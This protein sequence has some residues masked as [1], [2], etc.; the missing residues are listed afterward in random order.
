MVNAFPDSRTHYPTNRRESELDART[1]NCPK[2]GAR[3]GLP[4]RAPSGK[5]LPAHT[6]RL[7]RAY[8]RS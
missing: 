3:V 8:G 5:A 2:C 4:C 6:A 7:A 1:A